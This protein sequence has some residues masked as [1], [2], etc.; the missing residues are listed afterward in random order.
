MVNSWNRRQQ[1]F[2]CK[3]NGTLSFKVDNNCLFVSELEL[4][5]VVSLY[6][7]NASLSNM[8]LFSSETS[9]CNGVLLC[10]LISV[11]LAQAQNEDFSAIFNLE[12]YKGNA[13]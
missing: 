7:L 13:F 9:H 2:S 12:D 3:M 1:S 5:L 6:Q 4:N 8:Y 10:F 11:C